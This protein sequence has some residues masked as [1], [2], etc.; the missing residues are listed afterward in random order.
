[1]ISALDKGVEQTYLP[2]D[3]SEE[4]P[5][6]LQLRKLM[7]Y[8]PEGPCIDL[9]C[10]HSAPRGQMTCKTHRTQEF[11][12]RQRHVEFLQNLAGVQR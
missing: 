8:L 11:H 9:D 12:A 1:M 10:L 7:A 5:A 3:A 2:Q 4:V 6:V